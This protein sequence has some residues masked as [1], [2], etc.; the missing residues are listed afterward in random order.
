MKT[1]KRTVKELVSSLLK[2]GEILS[3]KL[4]G[5]RTYVIVKAFGHTYWI[6]NP[7]GRNPRI[8]QVDRENVSKN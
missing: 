5:E 1:T 2:E 8:S 6:A 3:T 7:Y 4:L